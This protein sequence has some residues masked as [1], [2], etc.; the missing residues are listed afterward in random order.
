MEPGNTLSPLLYIVAGI[1]LAVGAL[2]PG[3]LSFRRQVANGGLPFATLER[4]RYK[5][6]ARIYELEEE[7]KALRERQA[8]FDD[9]RAN[10]DRLTL[11]NLALHRKVD[12]MQVELDQLTR[13]N[14]MLRGGNK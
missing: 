2:I 6:A 5:M 10:V 8:A 13:E 11:E 14:R 9:L 12:G 3:V 4:D 7:L 1:S